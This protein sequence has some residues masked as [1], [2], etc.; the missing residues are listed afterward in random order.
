MYYLLRHQP[1]TIEAIAERPCARIP[2]LKW[3]RRRKIRL[4][5]IPVNHV[6]T[7]LNDIFRVWRT[8]NIK[9]KFTCVIISWNQRNRIAGK[10]ENPLTQQRDATGVKNRSAQR[11]HV[12][13]SPI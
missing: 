5:R 7:D 8:P 10:T 2:K 9:C 6:R 11:R 12:R 13:S 3:D 4:E 1:D